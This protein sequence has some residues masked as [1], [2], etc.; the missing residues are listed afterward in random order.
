MVEPIRA[1]D[2]SLDDDLL[3]FRGDQDADLGE[4]HRV[5]EGAVVE[6][7]PS[8]RGKAKADENQRDVINRHGVEE[9]R[10]CEDRGLHNAHGHTAVLHP[11]DK[12]FPSG[13]K[14]HHRSACAGSVGRSSA[15]GGGKTRD[16]GDVNRPVIGVP[17]D[18]MRGNTPSP[19]IWISSFLPTDSHQPASSQPP[20]WTRPKRS[21]PAFAEMLQS[22]LAR[23]ALPGRRSEPSG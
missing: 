21:V 17:S 4:I 6:R 10:Q 13:Y 12:S 16:L 15:N 18:T 11:G 8:V 3:V 14:S 19:G 22:R 1:Q 7:L 23:M 2:G 20:K 9:D 5:S